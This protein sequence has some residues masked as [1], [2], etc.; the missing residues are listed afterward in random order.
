MKTFR[1][2]SIEEKIKAGVNLYAVLKNIEE[3]VALDA[4]I[5][6]LVKDWRI[7]IE[8]RVRNGPVASV[9]F[10][11]GSCKVIK[12]KLKKVDVILYFMSE[13]HLNKMFDGKANPIPLK[14]FTK[15]GFLDKEFSKVTD[16]LEYYLKPTDQL[17]SDPDYH[18]INTIFTLT[19]AVHAL[20]VIM[21][22][23][24]KAQLTGSHLTKGSLRIKVKNGPS[25]FVIT[26]QNVLEIVSESDQ[27]ATCEMII[28]DTLIANKFFSGKV[29]VFSALAKQDIEINGQTYLLD[30]IG[31]ILDRIP[32]YVN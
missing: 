31:L 20:P 6:T 17:L 8:F 1:A 3:L 11:N 21:K 16:K 19:T 13:S 23:D 5:K 14:G 2:M 4:E 15:L 12:G 25:A 7:S 24:P 10:L 26:D 22:Y 27:E 29:D 32:L 30:N 28:K 9:S 18:R